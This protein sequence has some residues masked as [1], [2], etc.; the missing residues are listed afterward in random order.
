MTNITEIIQGVSGYVSGG[1][2]IG[3]A[4]LM[5]VL[6]RKVISVLI[7][8]DHGSGDSDNYHDQHVQDENYER[9]YGNSSWGKDD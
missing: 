1:V 3:V 5:F 9:Y 8:D 7:A 2:A 4:V 6:G